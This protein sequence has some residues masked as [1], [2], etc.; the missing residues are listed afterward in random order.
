LFEVE[1]AA[2]A[3]DDPA[4]PDRAEAARPDVLGPGPVPED[5]V[6]N[7]GA[8]TLLGAAL[9]EADGAPVIPG[10]LTAPYGFI[11]RVPDIAGV[12]VP[13]MPVVWAAAE[14]A[15]TAITKTVM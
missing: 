9:R 10:K 5:P 15:R 13:A 6:E 14:P 4:D 11:R 3:E 8:A 1:G 12:A 7:T 2:A